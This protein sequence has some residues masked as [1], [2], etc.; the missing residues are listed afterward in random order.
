MAAIE[1]AQG[2]AAADVV[3][4][5]TKVWAYATSLGGVES[6]LERR[7]RWP[8]ES[9]TVPPDLIRL[10]FGIENADDLWLD[11]SQAL[12]LVLPN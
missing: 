12:D 8:L 2:A 3:C 4:A 11:L 10:S 9:E 7:R 6:L 1:I 5:N